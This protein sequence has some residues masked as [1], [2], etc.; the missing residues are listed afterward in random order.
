MMTQ[1][2]RD[3]FIIFIIFLLNPFIAFFLS[4]YKVISDKKNMKYLYIIAFFYGFF[5]LIFLSEENYDIRAHYEIFKIVSK[6]NWSQYIIY[7]MNQKDILILI[8][9]RI[10]SF[11]TTN[12]RWIG[13]F[14][15]ILSYGIPF[16]LI[17][18]FG[19]KNKLKKYEILLFLLL[20]LG[21]TPSYKF[22]GMRNFNAVCLFSL[23]V[24]YVD[25]L[26][27]KKGYIY[28]ILSPL[29]HISMLIVILIYL[30]SKKIKITKV[31]VWISFISSGVLL[32]FSKR[33]LLM[34]L[35]II[36]SYSRFISAYIEGVHATSVTAS[37]IV[38]LIYYFFFFSVYALFYMKILKEK[39]VKNLSF[40]RFLIYYF[41]FLSIFS[42]SKTMHIRYAENII[43]LLFMTL[44][45]LYSKYFRN[46]KF[47]II[48]TIGFGIFSY[49]LMVKMEYKTWN[50]KLISNSVLSIIKEAENLNNSQY[51]KLRRKN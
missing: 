9:Y 8:Y 33:I 7:S 48:L 51:I 15:A 44:I 45:F 28:L 32:L 5:G 34:M 35:N 27:S 29:L 43:L 39:K 38:I 30:I 10:L 4:L 1:K 19:H 2:I 37:K 24:Y 18:D 17:V 36:P 12:P 11:I 23:G 46:N 13:F 22:S 3:Y 14:S 25:I 50:L 20:F 47:F 41:S 40:Y 49:I 42:F 21:I 6:Q 31:K 16:Y 26:K